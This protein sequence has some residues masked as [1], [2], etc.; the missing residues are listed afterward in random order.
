LNAVPFPSH[1]GGFGGQH[2]SAMPS[3]AHPLNAVPFPSHM[4][5]FG[6]QHLDGLLADAHA[7]AHAHAPAH[8]ARVNTTSD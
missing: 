3:S 7:H 4:G 5:G 1:M 2:L 6:G 8:P